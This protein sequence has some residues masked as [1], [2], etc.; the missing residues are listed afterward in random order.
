MTM[1]APLETYKLILEHEYKDSHGNTFKMDEPITC[2]F[3]IDNTGPLSRPFCV[4][5]IFER[6]YHEMMRY[7]AKEEREKRYG[8]DS[9]L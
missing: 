4:N 7:L 2:A 1:N 9:K 6:L 8:V 5:E 3:T